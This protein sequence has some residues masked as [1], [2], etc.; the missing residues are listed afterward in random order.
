MENLLLTTV[1]P[2]LSNL[3]NGVAFL[4]TFRI[5]CH[6]TTC[7]THRRYSCPLLTTSSA[8][9]HVTSV[10][11]SL[12]KLLV[13]TLKDKKMNL[14][15]DILKFN[16]ETPDFLATFKAGLLEAKM[17]SQNSRFRPSTSHS[18]S[19]DSPGESWL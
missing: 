2:Y 18:S 8:A 1:K 15:S 19:Y 10:N 11:C 7:K 9:G 13:I 17:F 16:Y 14:T 12:I 4:A 5:C 6:R 3:A